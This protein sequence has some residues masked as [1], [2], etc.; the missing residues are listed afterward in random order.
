MLRKILKWTSI[1]L[2][3]LVGLLVLTIVAL[4]IIG[5]AMWNRSRWNYDVP[6]EAITIP[7]DQASIARGEHIATIRMC[8]HCH[9]DTLSGQFATV[10]GLVT[11][12]IPN[13]TSGA[14]GVGD[15]NTDEDWVRAIRHG[16]GH[17]GRGL[18][19][20]P[21]GGFLLLERRRPRH[22]LPITTGHTRPARVLLTGQN[23]GRVTEGLRS[24]IT[25][26]HLR[27]SVGLE[28]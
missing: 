13:L 8:R 5:G 19:L 24:P 14:G 2:G 11:L 26:P 15:T 4:Y 22:A 3:S 9:T 7:T 27:P 20:M 1:V 6:V 16:I 21:S 12:S 18:A 28:R 10:P 25:I 17:D 23:L